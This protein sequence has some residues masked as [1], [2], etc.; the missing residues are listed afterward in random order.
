MTTAAQTIDRVRTSIEEPDSQFFETSDYVRAY[1]DALDE[2]SELTEINESYIYVKRRS[3][4]LYTSLQGILPP[5]FLRVTSVYNPSSGKW[6]DPT[7]IRE[8]DLSLGRDFESRAD[9]SRWWFMRGLWLL[10]AYPV[11]G[12]DSSPLKVWY[13]SLLPHIEEDGGNVSGL[14]S[15]PDIPDDYNPAL[16]NYMMYQLLSE[17]KEVEKSLEYYRRFSD[18]ITGLKD[19]AENRMRRDRIPRIGARR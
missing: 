14:G 6:M 1:N 5:T 12:N 19:I 10:G 15:S 3:G 11:A 8:L 9:E 2:V 13:C 16:E 17:R 4:S 18:Q 7:T